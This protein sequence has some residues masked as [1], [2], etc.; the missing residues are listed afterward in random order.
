MNAICSTD[1]FPQEQR[2]IL[3]SI[4]PSALSLPVNV[5]FSIC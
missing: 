3:S 1:L 2:E 4:N 5:H